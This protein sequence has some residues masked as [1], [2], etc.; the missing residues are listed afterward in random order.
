[1]T[2][3][4][5]TLSLLLGFA[6]LLS[7]CLLLLLGRVQRTLTG[8]SALSDSRQPRPPRGPGA[9]TTLA[10]VD[11]PPLARSE[12]RQP[13][14]FGV[15]L[16]LREHGDDFLPV[17]LAISRANLLEIKGQTI[18]H[19]GKPVFIMAGHPSVMPAAQRC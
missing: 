7:V 18:T 8:A 12:R 6:V 3:Q 5:L 11:P 9:S 15:P 16:P 13:R 17:E 14:R 1:M 2:D 4:Q 19:V 10:G